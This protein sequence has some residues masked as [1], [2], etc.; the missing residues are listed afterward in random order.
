[1][2]YR[3]EANA[4]LQSWPALLAAVTNLNGQITG[5]Q[6]SWL[7]VC[8]ASK[9][10]VNDPRRA[11]GHLLGNGVRFGIPSDLVAVGEGI[12][13]MLSL[14]SVLPNLPVI[15]GLSANHLAALAFAPPWRRL[16]VARDNDLAGRRAAERLRERGLA[17]SIEVRD[18]VPVHDDFNLDLRCLG[19]EGLVEQLK[20]QFAAEDVQ[21]FFSAHSQIS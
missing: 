16:Y 20:P 7:D 4:P 5:I 2:W 14:L 10:P 19:P 12:E 1:M 3:E 18:L 21:R 8:S 9:A 17:S 6:R 15:A 11:L 13:T